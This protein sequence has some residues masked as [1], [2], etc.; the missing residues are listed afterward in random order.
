MIIEVPAS[1][2]PKPFGALVSTLAFGQAG[3]VEFA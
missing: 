1:S 3:I 2:L